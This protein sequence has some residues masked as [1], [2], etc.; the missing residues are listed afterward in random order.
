MPLF[1]FKKTELYGAAKDGRLPEVE[2]LLAEG[3]SPEAKGGYN[4]GEPAL[5]AAAMGGHLDVLRALVGA[6]A[7]LDATDFQFSHGHGCGQKSTC[8][9]G[10]EGAQEPTLL[11]QH[12]NGREVL[13]A[14]Q[15]DVKFC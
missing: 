15:T 1:R 14:T 3:V 10:G 12:F 7:K 13:D 4:G 6:G 8:G 9:L 5:V 11:R 2:H